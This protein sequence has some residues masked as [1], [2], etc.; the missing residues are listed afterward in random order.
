MKEQNRNTPSK[1]STTLGAGPN[2]PPPWRL[3]AV[4]AFPLPVLLFMVAAFNLI[5]PPSS[6]LSRSLIFDP[7]LLF[8][9]LQIVFLTLTSSLVGYISLRGYLQN[10]STILILLGSG[11]VVWGTGSFIA[12][13]YIT[14]P[15][16]GISISNTSALVSSLFHLASGI[17]ASASISSRARPELRKP[18]LIL[19]YAGVF[20]F[21][22]L[23]TLMCV[24][25]MVPAFFVPGVG[26]T[27]LR[28]V[29]LGSASGVLAVCSIVFARLYL[30]SRSNT[31]YWYF[32][33]LGLTAA[34]LGAVFFG[35][36][37]GDPISWTGRTA[38]FLGG[39]Y[40]V[41]AVSSSFKH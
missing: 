39:V 19:A 38:M 22:G 2:Q 32:L 12:G 33:A 18:L 21:S 10:G 30:I 35:R 9:S 1:P 17:I 27:W 40:F 8:L 15:N 20:G 26:Q 14:Q 7:P 25:G 11:A 36:A 6:Q 3:K 31:L 23:F 4:G 28:M 24:A 5:L 13:L 16:I 34:G 41:K 29:V 37:P